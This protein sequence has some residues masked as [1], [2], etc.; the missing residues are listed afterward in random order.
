MISR[1][2]W[3]S[4][5]VIWGSMVVNAIPYVRRILQ[6]N[7][8][9][10]PVARREYY[11]RTRELKGRQSGGSETISG[12]IGKAASTI[13]KGSTSQ[14]TVSSP[15]KVNVAAQV[16]E[17]RVNELKGRMEKLKAKLNELLKEAEEKE[18]KKA[19]KAEKKESEGTSEKK[20][21]S[22]KQT[23]EEK[24]KARERSKDWYEE[25][26]E[27]KGESEKKEKKPDLETQ[28]KEVRQKIEETRVK[29][30]EA[31]ASARAKVNSNSTT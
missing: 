17:Q 8:D 19:E 13:A 27:L 3:M 21:S 20:E 26:K 30:E 16:T 6:H 15:P 2:R 12:G 9:Y 4:S 29:L 5:S 31:I 28:I 11:L 24:R 1:R 23:S 14:P 18:A 22:E 7:D 25:N 10:D